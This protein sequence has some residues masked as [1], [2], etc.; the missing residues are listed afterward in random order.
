MNDGGQGKTNVLE[1]GSGVP[2]GLS[3]PLLSHCVGKQAQKRKHWSPILCQ[4]SDGFLES[5]TAEHQILK[6]YLRLTNGRG[7]GPLGGVSEWFG[8]M[9]VHLQ[10]T[11]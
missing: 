9:G 11:C 2:K 5:F 1:F 4:Q 8:T 10:E 6:I 3:G 7:R